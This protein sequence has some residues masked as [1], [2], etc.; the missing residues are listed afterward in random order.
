M[1]TPSTE[2]S[3]NH[4]PGQTVTYVPGLYHRVIRPPHGT[5]GKGLL[6]YMDEKR[7]VQEVGTFLLSGPS[8]R[9]EA[10]R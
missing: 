7:G 10:C 3:V 5:R 8:R 2:K 9:P 6:A 4:V 1:P